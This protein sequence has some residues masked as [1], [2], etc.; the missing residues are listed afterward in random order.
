MPPV[1]SIDYYGRLEVARE[2]DLATGDTVIFGFRPQ[3]FVT[4]ALVAPVSGI[5]SGKPEVEG[6]WTSDGRP[7]AWDR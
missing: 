5:R 4:R 7:A 2:A 1:G 3:V 6:I